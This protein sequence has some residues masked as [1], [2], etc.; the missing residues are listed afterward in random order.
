MGNLPRQRTLH[1]RPETAN[2]LKLGQVVGSSYPQKLWISKRRLAGKSAS[3]IASPVGGT[4]RY[5][6]APRVRIRHSFHTKTPTER[7]AC[8]R[9]GS[10]RHSPT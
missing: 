8:A 6:A 5:R 4:G 9:N 3:A 2:G 10:Q 7:G 1:R